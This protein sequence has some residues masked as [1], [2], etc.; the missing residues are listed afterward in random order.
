MLR[1]FSKRGQPISFYKEHTGN[2]TSNILKTPSYSTCFIYHL[3]CPLSHTFRVEVLFAQNTQK[4]SGVILNKPSI[5]LLRKMGQGHATHVIKCACVESLKQNSNNTLCNVDCS[6]SFKVEHRR[7]T[8]IL[9][10]CSRKFDM[11][12][13]FRRYIFQ[14]T[15]TLP[16]FSGHFRKSLVEKLA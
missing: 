13:T 15:H 9:F 8:I 7:T 10:K 4:G 6:A 14:P 12:F 5:E 2:I 11:F 1:V 3:S 16:C